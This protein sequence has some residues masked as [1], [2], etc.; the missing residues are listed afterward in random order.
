MSSGCAACPEP[1]TTNWGLGC[2]A[3]SSDAAGMPREDG[4][5]VEGI[6]L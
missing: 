3:G 1:E 4:G 6:V 2:V 5:S